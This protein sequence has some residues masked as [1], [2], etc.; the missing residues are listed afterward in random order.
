V[1]S[2][3]PE[4]PP[5]RATPRTVRVYATPEEAAGAVASIVVRAAREAIEARGRFA[6]AL[7]GGR[8]PLPLFER[9]ARERSRDVDWSAVH[10]FWADERCV[11]P[12]HEDSNYAAARMHLLDRVP[13]PPS[14]VHRI[15]GEVTPPVAAGIYRAELATFFHAE[16]PAE[17]AAGLDL[18]LL[19]IGGDGHV[20]SIFPGSAALDVPE[21]A[22]DVQAPVGIIA[23]WRVTLTRAALAAADHV[24]VLATGAEKV[25]AVAA[26]FAPERPT[27]AARLAARSCI[28]WVVDEAAAA[29]LDAR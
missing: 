18:V 8:T 2:L 6:L 21:W 14:H 9:L 16:T 5:P 3:E 26:A 22:L 28:T 24:L 13:I 12:D 1:S 11:P 19:G 4:R 29:A 15:R 10:V 27:P 23:R 25:G 17:A 20:A 7:S